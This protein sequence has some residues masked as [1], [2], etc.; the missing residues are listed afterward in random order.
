MSKRQQILDTTLDLIADLGFKHA[1]LSLIIKKSNAAAGTIYYH[2]KNKEELIDT[3]YSELKAEMGKAIIRNLEQQ[4]NTKEKFFLI[5]KNLFSYYIENP[6]KF[7]FLEDY[8]NSPL[9][10]KEIKAINKRHY[11]TAIDYFEYGIEFGM[12]RDLNLDL[13]MNLVF[14]NISTL[15]RMVIMEE[16]ELNEI[17][18]NNTIQSSWDSVKIN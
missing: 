17:I 1:S 10:R 8:T 16:I 13:M 12:L 15:A 4:M 18:L 3:L 11:Q 9:V 5:W 6:K 2:F 7:E 14:G